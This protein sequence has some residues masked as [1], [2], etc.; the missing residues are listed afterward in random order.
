MMKDYKESTIEEIVEYEIVFYGEPGCGYAY[1]FPCDEHGNPLM[2]EMNKA[3]WENYRWALLHPEK[4][5]YKFN[6][7]VREVR[8]VRNPP[9]GIC[10]CGDRVELFNEYLGGCE[11]PRC[12]QWWN[13]FGQELNNPDTWSE[14]DDW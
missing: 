1:A 3:A 13:L 10:H 2:D 6:K 5:P 7:I 14:G 9:S 11:C 8:K 4:F 12:G